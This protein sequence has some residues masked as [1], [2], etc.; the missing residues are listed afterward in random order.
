MCG[1]AAAGWNGRN[2]PAGLS[3]RVRGSRP[4]RRS[5]SPRRGPIPACAGEPI[6]AYL[7]AA[8]SRAYPRVCGGA[9]LGYPITVTEWGLSPRVRGSRRINVFR[10]FI[11]GP[12]PACA[13]EPGGGQPRYGQQRAYP[14]VC[15]GAA[16]VGECAGSA[17]GLS[18]RVRGSLLDKDRK[19][20]RSG[21]IP[22]CAGE[23]RRGCRRHLASGAYPRVCGGATHT[24]TGTRES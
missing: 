4:R 1:G 8:R 5:R 2:P 21:P 15:G 22:A 11:E 20:R 3:P 23:P 17:E 18:P 24:G 13:G 14:R 6:S 7:R 12:I 19:I 9:A 16:S 10:Y